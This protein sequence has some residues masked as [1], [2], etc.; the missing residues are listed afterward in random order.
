[1]TSLSGCCA[2]DPFQTCSSIGGVPSIQFNSIPSV[3]WNHVKPPFNLGGGHQPQW[4]SSGF[5]H[6]APHPIFPQRWP[7]TPKPWHLEGKG[8][9]TNLSQIIENSRLLR[10]R[11]LPFFVTLPAPSNPKH[12]RFVCHTIK[13][14]VFATCFVKQPSFQYT[15]LKRGWSWIFLRNSRNIISVV[16]CVPCLPSILWRSMILTR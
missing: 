7:F 3:C 9:L 8:H 4:Y 11:N 13:S 2:L 12:K 15:T 1:M 14:R 6:S 16:L 5:L 10:P